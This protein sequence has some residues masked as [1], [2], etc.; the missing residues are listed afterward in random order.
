MR[1]TSSPTASPPPRRLMR[2][3]LEAA[4]AGHYVFPLW[5]RSKKPSIKNWEQAATRDLAAIRERWATLPWNVG[6]ACGPSG[7]LVIDLDDAHGHEPPEEWAGA[8][9]GRDVFA[10]LAEVAGEPYPAHTYA[11]Q[12]PRGGEHLY[13]R[14]SAEP[15]LRNTSGRL[16]WRID[17]RG[18]GGYIVAA[19][20]VRGEGLYV[21][22][23]RAP[24]APLPQWLVT[25]LT[26]PP[27]PEPAEFLPRQ[28]RHTVGELDRAAAYLE[29]V[30][31]NVAL[32]QPGQRH[33]TLIR[34]AYTLGRLVAGGD[35]AEY[36]ARAALHEAAA[37]H[38]GVDDWSTAEAEQT[39]SDGLEAGGHHPRCLADLP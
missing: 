28:N 3:A 15:E 14:A 9:H 5:P 25:Q 4:T 12:S 21:A 23:N 19:G 1:P 38:V 36:D 7:L 27:L 31:E 29:R 22:L 32:A 35:I 30:A 26:P 39:I 20:S 2:A 17:T 8:R 10:R 24:I 34:A 16:G 18:A 11:V 33:D 6:I 13:F 37:R